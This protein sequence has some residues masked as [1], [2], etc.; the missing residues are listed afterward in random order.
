M[1]ELKTRAGVHRSW[2]PLALVL[3]FAATAG[4]TRCNLGDISLNA[5]IDIIGNGY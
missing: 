2:C 1:R 3:L 5:A 4:C